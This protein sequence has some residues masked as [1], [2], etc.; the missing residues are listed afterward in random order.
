MLKILILA[1]HELE[2]QPLHQPL[3]TLAA[4]A[5]DGLS[6]ELASVGV[7]L[8]AA[9]AGSARALGRQ[10]PVD[11]AILVGSYGRYRGHGDFEPG[12]LLV[13]SALELLD[14]ALLDGRAAVPDPMPQR[15]ELDAD[16]RGGLIEALALSPAATRLATTLAITTDDALAARLGRAGC[17]GENLEALAVA[18]ACRLWNVPLG[19]LLACTNVVGAAG[20]AQWLAHRETAAEATRQALCQWLEH[21][22]PGLSQPLP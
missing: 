3:A 9:G 6:L 5:G 14:G 13:P 1:A 19:V 2:L 7:G 15:L 12:Q 22:A 18:E 16:L 21:G 20:R 17:E 10:G 4:A 11:A 8:T